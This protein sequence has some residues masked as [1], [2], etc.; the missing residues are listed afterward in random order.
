MTRITNLP[1]LNTLTNQLLFPVADISQSPDRTRSITVSQLVSLV[2]GGGNVIETANTATNIANGATGLI[3][4]QS[5]AG[6]TAFDTGF[7]YSAQTDQLIAPKFNLG[8]EYI[9][10]IVT[11][12]LGATSPD[13]AF[14]IN[15][16]DSNIKLIT[17]NDYSTLFVGNQDGDVN[18]FK[19]IT[20]SPITGNVLINST[21]V[22]T[23]PSTGALVVNGGVGIDGNVYVTGSTFSNT[24]SDRRL[25]ENI[26]PIENPLEIISQITGT[27]FDWTDSYI[28]SVGGE[29]G[30]FVKKHDFGVIAQDIEKVLP[31]I[32]G[33]KNDGF[34]TVKYEKLIPL[35]IESVKALSTEVAELKEQLAKLQ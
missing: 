9:G 12:N 30:N 5:G 31:E 20:V 18:T 24:P 6:R 35:L 4:F 17:V 28:E 15:N 33:T 7:K 32:V 19:G 2:G 8:N 16:S 25:K 22:A 14:S 23:S 10:D 34:K 11:I 27:R 29:D 1:P 26:T 3:P 21:Q 13:I